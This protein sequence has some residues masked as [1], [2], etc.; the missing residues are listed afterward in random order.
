LQ[1]GKRLPGRS[2]GPLA[3]AKSELRGPT[4]RG[5]G[6]RRDS[7]GRMPGPRRCSGP[8]ARLP[9]ACAHG[10]GLGHGQRRNSPFLL[11]CG[12]KPVEGGRW[13]VPGP[14]AGAKGR[15]LRPGRSR[16]PEPSTFH[17]P[18]LPGFGPE[19]QGEERGEF[20]PELR[21]RP[22]AWGVSSPASARAGGL[23]L[24]CSPAAQPSLP[25]RSE[26]RKAIGGG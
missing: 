4:G 23:S 1:A 6:R 21:P 22:T 5:R 16:K 20:L 26:R 19:Q 24:A 12:G 25:G 18:G 2:A 17:L 8:E 11:L 10:G 9:S 13:K 7:P 3:G 15:R 14:V